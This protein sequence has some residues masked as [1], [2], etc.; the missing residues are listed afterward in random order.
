MV[1]IGFLR[2]TLSGSHGCFRLSQALYHGPSHRTFLARFH[3]DSNDGLSAVSTNNDSKSGQKLGRQYVLRKVASDA[4]HLMAQLDD[5][6]STPTVKSLKNELDALKS[7]LARVEK[8]TEIQPTS[9]PKDP[10]A[11]LN[12]NQRK[13]PLKSGMTAEEVS[14]NLFTS[15][16][17]VRINPIYLR[18]ACNCSQ[19]VDPS[20][21]QRNYSFVDIPL[22][23]KPVLEKTDETHTYHVSWEH[24]VPG[25][26][27]SHISLFPTS[28]I[29]QL[30][31]DRYGGRQHPRSVDSASRQLW[32]N[33]AFMKR[34]CWVEYEEYMNDTSSLRSAV[35]ALRRDGLIFVKNVPP[36]ASSVSKVAERIGP[37]R[38][39]IYGATWDVR[40]VTDAKNVAYTSKYLGFH[41]DLL[42]MDSPPEFQLLHCIHN[43]CAG[44]E[45]RFVDTYKA[46]KILHEQAPDMA[47]ALRQKKV[48]YTYDNDGHYYTNSHR[49]FNT[50][51][52]RPSWVTPDVNIPGRRRDLGNINWSPEFMDVPGIEGMNETS[53]Q[54]FLAGARMF[55]QTLEREDL[56]Y[57]VKMEEGTCVI[58]ENR[59]VAHARNAFEM[60]TGER[61]LRGAYLDYDT[62]WS[63][64]KVL[65][66]ADNDQVENEE[67]LHAS[68]AT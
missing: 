22:I 58:F 18:D 3:N 23:I 57:Q 13:S 68:E 6:R 43:S 63:K 25:F 2:Q 17:G 26:D 42:Y 31:K 48:T 45:S 64:Y 52:S 1:R 50:E 10:S 62:F 38:N 27:G 14:L 55:A 53:T 60:K 7:A 5:L 66:L 8:R 4:P 41:M 67:D 28:R 33:A 49:I 46:A 12:R 44:G 21:R 29:Q 65:G 39:T 59:R 9:M 40:S 51:T 47:R 19:C 30:V 37:L 20:T 56:V 54:R 11:Q 61:W 34:G 15:D 32:D 24:D 35:S 36:E 16:G